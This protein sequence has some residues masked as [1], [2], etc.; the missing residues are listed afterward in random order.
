MKIM[1]LKKKVQT[2]LEWGS[3]IGLFIT[4]GFVEEAPV[5]AFI[6]LLIFSI[7]LYLVYRYGVFYYE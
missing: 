3:L 6:G 2:K 1:K 7:P 5:V 4:G